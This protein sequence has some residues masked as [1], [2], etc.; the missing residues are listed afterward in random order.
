MSAVSAGKNGLNG[1]SVLQTRLAP[2]QAPH[3]STATAAGISSSSSSLSCNNVNYICQYQFIMVQSFT[4]R[5]NVWLWLTGSVRSAPVVSV[6]IST[7]VHNNCK[8]FGEL[9]PI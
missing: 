4:T 3:L 7:A 6:V 2:L 5:F 1:H 8:L 9:A